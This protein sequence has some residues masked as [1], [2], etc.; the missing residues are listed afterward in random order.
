MESLQTLQFL[1]KAIATLFLLGRAAGW[2]EYSAPEKCLTRRR[3]SQWIAWLLLLKVPDWVPFLCRD[4]GDR[5]ALINSAGRP[6]HEASRALIVRLIQ[7]NYWIKAMKIVVCEPLW[8]FLR[9]SPCAVRLEVSQALLSVSWLAIS[10]PVTV[11]LVFLRS[12]L[13]CVPSFY[14]ACNR[15]HIHLWLG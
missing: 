5:V 4:C 12:A 9:L 8:I 13:L 6:S 14:V 15:S 10:R 2:C 7:Q 3:L 1:G 11:M